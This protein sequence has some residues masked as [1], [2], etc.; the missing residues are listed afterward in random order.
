MV[1]TLGEFNCLIR[2]DLNLLGIENN[3]NDGMLDIGNEDTP[4]KQ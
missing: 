3:V 4:R 1:M 2:N